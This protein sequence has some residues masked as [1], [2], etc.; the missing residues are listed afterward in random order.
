MRIYAA[1]LALAI[2][3]G[4][5]LGYTLALTLASRERTA[6]LT[7]HN[8][9]HARM[10]AQCRYVADVTERVLTEAPVI[11]RAKCGPTGDTRLERGTE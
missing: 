11:L 3:C 8:E 1:S 9:G 5:M 4:A 6:R 2:T 7:A 10:E